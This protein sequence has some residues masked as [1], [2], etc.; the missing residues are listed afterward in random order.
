MLY[1]KRTFKLSYRPSHLN[2]HQHTCCFKT[3]SGSFKINLLLVYLCSYVLSYSCTFLLFRLIQ[4]IFFATHI[5][6]E[7]REKYFGHRINMNLNILI[8]KNQCLKLFFPQRHFYHHTA[9]E[10]YVQHIF[11]F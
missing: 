6:R 3:N 4:T 11:I 2:Y 8:Y 1:N 10:L 9:C 5:L 7:K